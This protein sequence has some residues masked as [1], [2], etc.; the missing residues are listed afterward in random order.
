MALGSTEA[1]I[2]L[3]TQSPL[4]LHPARLAGARSDQEVAQ[5]V[6]FGLLQ[7]EPIHPVEVEH[8]LVAPVEGG[9]LTGFLEGW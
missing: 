3:I 1:L 5:K 2:P 7:V 8:D 4:G 9:G 6:R